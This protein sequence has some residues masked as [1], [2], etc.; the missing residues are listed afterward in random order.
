MCTPTNTWRL[1]TVKYGIFCHVI[2]LER[3][4]HMLSGCPN[5][6]LLV[7]DLWKTQ[8]KEVQNYTIHLSFFLWLYRDEREAKGGVGSGKR[9]KILIKQGFCIDSALCIRQKVKQMPG[10][11]CHFKQWLLALE[12]APCLPRKHSPFRLLIATRHGAW[13]CV[14]VC[15]VEVVG[16]GGGGG[17][18]FHFNLWLN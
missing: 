10:Q 18:A 8:K 14:N 11:R 13:M 15:V 4:L 7:V 16:R 2:Y 17:G 9:G 5:T 6:E 1:I 12:S 3:H